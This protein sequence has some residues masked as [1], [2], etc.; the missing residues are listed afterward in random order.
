GQSL[1]GPTGMLRGQ[2][3]AFGVRHQAEDSAS[4]VTDAGH[5]ALG[6]IRVGRVGAG[7]VA[8]VYVAQNDLPG[9]LQ[10][11][12]DPRLPAKEATFSVGYRQVK[13]LV[14]LEEGTARGRRA[15]VNPA[16]LE[17]P[18]DVAGQRGQRSVVVG[19]QKKSRLEQH[20]KAVANAQDQL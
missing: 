9:L 2:D 6:A 12:E 17:L 15:K 13:T 18:G 20:L 1:P 16:V 4:D 14:A 5:V 3:M 19:L 11:L 7:L 10:A 8:G